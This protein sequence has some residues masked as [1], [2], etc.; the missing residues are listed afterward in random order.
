MESNRPRST[1]YEWLFPRV[2]QYFCCQFSSAKEEKFHDLVHE[3]IKGNID[4]CIIASL[5]V[6]GKEVVSYKV[7]EQ[8]D[9]VNKLHS[10][11]VEKFKGRSPTSSRA[12]RRL[13]LKPL[14]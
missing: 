3:I 2:W 12:N 14:G 11:T 4:W 5:H 10:F 7:I 1:R 8:N 9:L 6:F 13:F